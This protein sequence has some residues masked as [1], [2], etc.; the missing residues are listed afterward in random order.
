MNLRYAGLGSLFFLGL[1]STSA[2]GVDGPSPCKDVEYGTDRFTVCEFPTTKTDVRLFWGEAEKPYGHFN[3]VA[4]TVR[5]KQKRLVFAMNAGMY[6]D[7]RAPVGLYVDDTGSRGRL[8]TKASYGNFGMLPNGVFHVSPSGMAVTESTTFKAEEIAPSYA[9]QSGPMLVIEDK[10]HPKF[11]R[12]STSKRIRNG[13]GVSADGE[14]VYFAM[15]DRPVTFYGFASLFK[16]QLNTPNALYLDGTI[17]R[18]Y[19]AATGRNDLGMAMGPIVGV[20]APVEM[21]T[22]EGAEP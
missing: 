5:S 11:N 2:F 7:D 12:N 14:T 13:V 21:N 10:L 18:L 9:T 17:S 3:T 16:D 1:M 15:S 6:L 22:K 19:D 4:Q 8:Q 20:V